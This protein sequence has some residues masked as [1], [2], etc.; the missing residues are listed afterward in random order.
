M[1]WK[2]VSYFDHSAKSSIL[3]ITYTEKP[4]VS[5]ILNLHTSQSNSAHQIA[6]LT[7]FDSLSGPVSYQCRAIMPVQCIC[8]C[9]RVKHVLS[10]CL[11]PYP[12]LLSLHHPWWSI[13]LPISLSPLIMGPSGTKLVR[14]HILS[15]R[16]IVIALFNN[17]HLEGARVTI[18]FLS[19]IIPPVHPCS[20]VLR[21]R[22]LTL[23]TTIM[24]RRELGV[25]LNSFFDRSVRR[26]SRGRTIK[27]VYH[28]VYAFSVRSSF[29]YTSHTL[30]SPVST[31]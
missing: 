27:S 20:F 17:V 25:V 2:F 9:V 4:I 26:S 13:L 3:E 29:S 24:C 7:A 23:N 8:V 10:L 6:I 11:N 16:L 1:Y 5:K 14:T 22:R 21:H 15:Y 12:R 18:Y 19:Y 28:S 30:P 31:G